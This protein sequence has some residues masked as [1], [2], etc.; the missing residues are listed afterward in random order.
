MEERLFDTKIKIFIVNYWKPLWEA[1]DIYIVKA[2]TPKEAKDK[3]V[4]KCNL[5]NSS[6]IIFKITE[7]SDFNFDNDGF[8]KYNI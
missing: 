1:S 4:N 8:L 3:V 2:N 7:L 5:K 6:S